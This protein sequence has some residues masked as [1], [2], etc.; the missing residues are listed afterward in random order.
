MRAELLRF[1][2][3]RQARC[4]YCRVPGSTLLDEMDRRTLS[5][6]SSCRP[7]G[8]GCPFR[9]SGRVLFPPQ[10][11]QLSTA[12]SL[13]L[14]TCARPRRPLASPHGPSARRSTAS[15]GRAIGRA[16]AFVCLFCAGPTPHSRARR[17]ICPAPPGAGS[18]ALSWLVGAARRV[19]SR[20]GA[21][22]AGRSSTSSTR[23]TRCIAR[24]LPSSTRHSKHEMRTVRC[25]AVQCDAVHRDAVRCSAMQCSAV[26]CD[27]ERS[28]AAHAARPAS[29]LR[30]PYSN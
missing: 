25:S 3:T 15:R 21:T 30:C 20:G 9:A 11:N 6:A 27:A 10:V 26:Q 14:H 8:A 5:T 19:R 17:P 13:V 24:A 18:A 4:E 1:D 28:A 12:K 29:S 16:I 22:P 23:R 2:L 7:T